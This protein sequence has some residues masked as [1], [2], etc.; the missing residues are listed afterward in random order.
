MS[1]ESPKTPS[2]SSSLPSSIPPRRT[3]KT[4]RA[5]S[6]TQGGTK[7]TKT[8]VETERDKE[9][10]QKEEVINYLDLE[11]MPPV[12]VDETGMVGISNMIF[13]VEVQEPDRIIDGVRH[14]VYTF[15][16]PEL[17]SILESQ[18]PINLILKTLIYMKKKE[19]GLD[20]SQEEKQD[21]ETEQIRNE[22]K[23]QEAFFN[24]N[25]E[26]LNAYNYLRLDRLEF[27]ND[28]YK[29]FLRNQEEGLARDDPDRERD[30]GDLF[31]LR[32]DFRNVREI[33][34][35]IRQE[36]LRENLSIEETIYNIDYIRTEFK[37]RQKESL[38]LTLF[39]GINE[40]I[41][42]N[43]VED[44]ESA[45]GIYYSNLTDMEITIQGYSTI[46][47]NRDL[48]IINDFEKAR[49]N[50]Y[51]KDIMLNILQVLFIIN[52]R[53]RLYDYKIWG[54]DHTE[55]F[56]KY[57]KYT[58]AF[59][60]T[61]NFFN[62]FPYPFFESSSNGIIDT[63][64][65]NVG[66]A[67][68]LLLVY[69]KLYDV[70]PLDFVPDLVNSTWGFTKEHYIPSMTLPP[71]MT[72]I[73]VDSL[74]TR[75]SVTPEQ[76]EKDVQKYLH[77]V[78][79]Q[80]PRADTIVNSFRNLKLYE[81]RDLV[82]ENSNEVDTYFVIE[83]I[84]TEVLNDNEVI[85]KVTSP[86]KAL[87]EN[88]NNFLFI[89]YN[90]YDKI[91]TN[92]N[93]TIEIL[94]F[95]TF[96]LP[97][98][99]REMDLKRTEYVNNTSKNI[100]GLQ[101]K[102]LIENPGDVQAEIYKKS[103]VGYNN[104]GR[105]L[106]VPVEIGEKMG[107]NLIKRYMT[108]IIADACLATDTREIGII[109]ENDP[110]NIKEHRN[111]YI[112]FIMTNVD[113]LPP[114]SLYRKLIKKIHNEKNVID[115]DFSY[116]LDMSSRE[117]RKTVEFNRAVDMVNAIIDTYM[118]QKPDILTERDVLYM[119]RDQMPPNTTFEEFLTTPEVFRRA[120]P[121]TLMILNFKI[122]MEAYAFCLGY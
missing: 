118:E 77:H 74:R 45:L 41:E 68:K 83:T 31:V 54:Q 29:I 72:F 58:D 107:Y 65:I 76:S 80:N 61:E 17:N 32:D 97:R 96:S 67:N 44:I 20:I 50:R 19:A 48:S 88:L 60:L 112:D 73:Y 70:S 85:E 10:K 18:Y 14:R 11:I 5:V 40:M 99:D 120:V 89:D 56:K 91:I 43:E 1:E 115:R 53:Y 106:G 109:K 33:M 34:Y 57:F 49:V 55:F 24:L 28:L 90:I 69:N 13:P 86:I 87:F 39:Q 8:P 92:L 6:R 93:R 122:L 42:N 110:I 63:S 30:F 37:N 51:K 103:G 104:Q 3:S 117:I 59:N 12:V 21:V 79:Y 66:S 105:R 15:Y 116:L 64:Q 2:S 100:R 35:E 108:P 52:V 98:V 71:D 75:V 38:Y 25:K 121:T 23:A 47:L 46:E 111:L 119:L 114:Q 95:G 102:I 78:I 82:S 26:E 113:M 62:G 84:I 81:T 4:S 22:G 94:N 27:I 9:Y 36:V 101:S 16:L 7:R